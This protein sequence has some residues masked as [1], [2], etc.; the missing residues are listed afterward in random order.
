M[1]VSKLRNS[2]FWNKKIDRAVR[3][4]DTDGDG[5][6]TRKDYMLARERFIQERVSSKYMADLIK[7]QDAIKDD[8]VKHSYDQFK[9]IILEIIEAAGEKYKDNLRNSFKTLDLN[10]ASY[11]SKN[12][13]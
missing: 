6:I 9:K 12:G 8:S 10:E 5:F 11:L 2:E 13:L 4:R 1:D 7:R 3:L